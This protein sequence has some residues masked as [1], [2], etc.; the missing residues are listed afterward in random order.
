MREQYP[1]VLSTKE[2]ERLIRRARA[3]WRTKRE[4]SEARE[5]LILHNLRL[6][7]KELHKMRGYTQPFEELQQAGRV[8]LILAVDR[9]DPE[10]AGTFPTLASQYIRQQ[11][12]RYLQQN[13]D[14]VRWTSTTGP[15]AKLVRQYISELGSEATP[16]LV[17]EKLVEHKELGLS[18]KLVRV[19]LDLELVRDYWQ[20]VGPDTTVLS[21][22]YEPN[23]Q[24][25]ADR[26][27]QTQNYLVSRETNTGEQLVERELVESIGSL[28]LLLQQPV[29]DAVSGKIVA[30]RGDEFLTQQL[31]LCMLAHPSRRGRFGY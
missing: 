28:P 23:P 9:A 31:G 27:Q 5:K 3:K 11:V 1:P 29:L 18:R 26:C 4:R 19:R 7:D 2:T 25:E 13:M 14:S 20:W 17:L 8:G 22:D 24:H 12:S 21:I 15:I 30:S 10:R 16:E 6:V